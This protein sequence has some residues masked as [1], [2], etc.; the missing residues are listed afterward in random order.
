M[1]LC[2]KHLA[3]GG[4]WAPDATD[5]TVSASASSSRVVGSSARPAS[6]GCTGQRFR[7]HHGR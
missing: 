6:G 7:H 1:A 5:S 4:V 2:L 3:R